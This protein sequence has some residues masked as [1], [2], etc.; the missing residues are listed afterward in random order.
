MVLPIESYHGCR[1]LITGGSGFIGHHLRARL[2]DA[3]AKV[4]SVDR[5]GRSS[6]EDESSIN[7]DLRDYAKLQ[8]V[9]D[10][11]SPEIVFHLAADIDRTPEFD[12]IYRMVE[13]NLI[14][15]I[16]LFKCLRE[17]KGL[18][19]VIVAGTAE[20]YGHNPIPFHEESRENPVS[21]YSFSKAC[22]SQLAGLAAKL[23]G[24]PVIV[25]RAALVY[26]PGQGPNML[27]P[28][29]IQTLLRGER[30]AMTGGEQ[31]RD[32]VF[33]DDL[34]EA[35]IKAGMAEAHQGEIINIGSGEAH[36]IKDIANWIALY[37]HK[38]HLI[39]IGAQKYR[40]SEVMGYVV[41]ITRARRML[42]WEPQTPLEEG[43]RITI[44]SYRSKAAS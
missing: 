43:L 33:I 19:K 12:A 28:A 30:F 27:I 40:K 7:C 25:V 4:F 37:L 1:V 20:E 10:G 8:S 29:L 39:D 23:Y 18:Q 3:G 13:G 41:D 32:F 42:N 26:G 24:L 22:V 2:S 38:D 34:V 36:K 5:T 31:T 15:T 35:Y 6:S 21:P 16:N 44:E 17:W 9:T 14:G 11:V